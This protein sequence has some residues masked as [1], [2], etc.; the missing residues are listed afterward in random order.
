MA[1]FG[2]RATGQYIEVLCDDSGHIITEDTARARARR[3]TILEVSHPGLNKAEVTA[4]IEYKGKLYI[5]VAPAGEFYVF[6][7]KTATLAYA[8]SQDIPLEQER[9]TFWNA[10]IFNDVLY[11][12]GGRR[13]PTGVVAPV[14]RF[15][16]ST[17]SIIKEFTGEGAEA[18]GMDVF[19][20]NLY[21]GFTYWLG[22]CRR[23]EIWRF[24]GS[25]WTNVWS[26]PAPD[27]GRIADLR[28]VVIGGVEYL[29][30]AVGHEFLVEAPNTPAKIYRS[31]DGST[32]TL[33]QTLS[34]EYGFEVNGL[35][36]YLDRV[37][38]STVYTGHVYASDSTGANFKLC[39]LP[40]LGTGYPD[41]E[42]RRM[43][44]N[45]RPLGQMLAVCAY[46]S[47]DVQ[48]KR[49]MVYAVINHVFHRLLDSSYGICSAV[50]YNGRFYFGTNS[51]G[52]WARM[53]ERLCNGIVYEV[54]PWELKPI[55]MFPLVPYITSGQTIGAGATAYFPSEDGLLV[56]HYKHKTWSL[57]A[58]YGLQYRIQVNDGIDWRDYYTVTLT[59]NTY[60]AKSTEELFERIRVAVY[61]PD[62]ASHTLTELAIKGW[63]N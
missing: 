50:M 25:A 43:H 60:E 10:R 56:S 39:G 16:G 20:G 45:L 47:G 34:N 18:F 32:F 11:F 44:I 30:V 13:V 52:E 54:W 26:S 4:L 35:A 27:Y 49:G 6:D 22:G 46:S 58:N 29:Y 36:Q 5:A 42:S 40:D 37:Y 3:R 7:G 63:S 62:T 19:R 24:D 9:G 8:V 14:V 41:D 2:R 48:M 15:D 33:V 1:M 12:S 57:L 38:A 17:W 28:R 23:G 61:N 31:T 59:A 53:G 55:K 51:Y 21:V